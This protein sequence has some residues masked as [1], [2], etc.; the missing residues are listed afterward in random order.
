MISRTGKIQEISR[1]LKFYRP[2]DRDRAA[3][4][5]R[6]KFREKNFKTPIQIARNRAK[7]REE[8]ER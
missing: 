4:R 7:N 6:T 3:Q 8:D 1:L 5:N 2:V